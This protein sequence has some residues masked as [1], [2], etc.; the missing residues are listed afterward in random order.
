MFVFKYI[1]SLDCHLSRS[2]IIVITVL[3][4]TSQLP[5]SSKMFYIS[6]YSQGLCYS[7]HHSSVNVCTCTHPSVILSPIYEMGVI[8]L[9]IACPL[10]E[11]SDDS[12]ESL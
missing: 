2:S 7:V 12:W 9:T 10:K 4:L 3:T 11:D 5:H 8:T 6:V 1:E